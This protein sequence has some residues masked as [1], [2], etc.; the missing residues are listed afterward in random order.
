MF[1]VSSTDA[2]PRPIL[3]LW[4]LQRKLGGGWDTQLD[5]GMPSC[6]QRYP[7]PCGIMASVESG[8]E[9]IGG[10]AR[11]NSGFVP[12]LPLPCWGPTV[13]GRLSTCPGDGEQ[14]L[15]GGSEFLLLLCSVWLLLPALNRC[16]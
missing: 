11:S 13:L 1:W 8:E 9:G 12:K 15:E 5:Q 10:D 16:L 6:P 4:D 3:L 2:E 7:S 14:Q